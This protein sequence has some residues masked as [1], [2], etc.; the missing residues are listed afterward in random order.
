MRRLGSA[1]RRRGNGFVLVLV[2][3]ALG[4]IGLLAAAFITSARLR[5]SA[6]G[7]IAVAAQAE[8]LAEA[9]VALALNR[10]ILSGPGEV[11]AS[12]Y[13]SDRYPPM[14]MMPGGA[15][16]LILI[17]DE[18]GKVDINAAPPALL[19]ALL[20]GFHVES[21]R[22]RALA[23][24]IV[25]FR[26]APLGHTLLEKAAYTAAGLP[27]GPK[28]SL[29]Q[30]RF[31]LDQV[32]GMDVDL[33]NR[34]LPFITVHSGLSGV[35]PEQAPPALFAALTGSGRDVVDALVFNPYPNNLRRQDPRFPV[36]FARAGGQGARLVHAEIIMPG[37]AVGAHDMLVL[38]RP[39]PIGFIVKEARHGTVRF[40]Q[41]LERVRREAPSNILPCQ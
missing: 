40:R 34:L 31:E 38:L 17:E 2:I 19:E 6:G 22:A 21:G 41:Y 16:A 15:V 28:Y 8:A 27:F 29:F 3:W 32:L 14:C 11:G 4:L 35:D 39:E 5:L 20:K 30:T 10:L 18:S 25:T 13:D 23:S 12:P 36:S 33:F 37:G 9:A 7:N 24:N 1:P 26:G